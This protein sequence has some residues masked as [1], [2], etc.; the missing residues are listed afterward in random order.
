MSWASIS[1]GDPCL[2]QCNYN[3]HYQMTLNNK[4]KQ[5]H[6]PKLWEYICHEQS[7]KKL[8]EK[9]VPILCVSFFCFGKLFTKRLSE[10]REVCSQVSSLHLISRMKTSVLCVMTVGLKRS[11][12]KKNPDNAFGIKNC[13]LHLVTNSS[14]LA[15]RW[16]DEFSQNPKTGI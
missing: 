13:T 10:P 12:K 5:F 11:L 1:H 16:V 14:I 4:I 3:K 8:A 7:H 6:Q 9:W 15:Y 2:D